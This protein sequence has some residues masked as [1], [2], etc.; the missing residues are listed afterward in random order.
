MLHPSDLS[1]SFVVSAQLDLSATAAATARLPPR[2]G[3]SLVRRFP[4]GVQGHQGWAVDG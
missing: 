1:V 3:E 2:L 4:W